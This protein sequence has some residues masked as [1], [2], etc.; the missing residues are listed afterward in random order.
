MPS[1]IK[2]YESTEGSNQPL[3]DVIRIREEPAMLLLFT[4]DT[5]ET[6]LHYENDD[7]VRAYIPCATKSCPICH[8]GN[9]PKTFYLLPAYDIEATAVGAL[10][11]STERGPARLFSLIVPFLQDKNIQDK[12]ALVSRKQFRFHIESRVLPDN[13]DRGEL[14]ITS[15]LRRRESGLQLVSALPQFSPR[16]MA[17]IPRVRR[18]LEALGA[19]E[20]FVNSDN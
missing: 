6:R 9:P 7:S 20:Q 2:A 11:I 8:I 18:K 15:F 16:E 3:L 5:E 17:D 14:A 10:I 13:A 4:D 12:V 19:Y 1:L